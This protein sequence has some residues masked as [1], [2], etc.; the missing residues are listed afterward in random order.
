MKYVSGLLMI[1]IFSLTSE[2]CSA[3]DVDEQFKPKQLWEFI[4]ASEMP[5]GSIVDT[6]AYTT[7][8]IRYREKNSLLYKYILMDGWEN[9]WNFF[10]WENGKWNSFS[11]S[12]EVWYFDF[13]MGY[14]NN[15]DYIDIVLYNA[16][17]EENFTNNLLP[18]MPRLFLGNGESF[19]LSSPSCSPSL[20]G[21]FSSKLQIYKNEYT[22]KPMSGFL[23]SIILNEEQNVNR[24][25]KKKE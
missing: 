4:S 25:C 3:D 23:K 13:A 8:Y 19:S 24:I 17:E 6:D 21:M 16:L 7:H 15:D 9:G 2:N 11:S 12:Q 5:D 1:L 14:F 22:T 18:P 10:S 20:H